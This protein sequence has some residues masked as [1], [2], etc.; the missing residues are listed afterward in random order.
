MNDAYANIFENEFL[1]QGRFANSNKHYADFDQEQINLG[2]SIEL[3]HTTNKAIALK[4]ALDHL[5][6]ISDYYTRLQK[7]E[8]E[9]K[10][11]Q[12]S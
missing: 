2:I 11:Q 3:E 10:K 6:E 12:T 1:K 9:A 8:A 7:M 5:S 4:I